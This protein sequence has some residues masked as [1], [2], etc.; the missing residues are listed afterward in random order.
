[1]PL[2]NIQAAILQTIAKN[3]SLESYVAGASLLHAEPGSPR[4]SHDVDIFHDDQRAVA[5]SATTDERALQ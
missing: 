3:R 5:R 1:M 4:I 2:S